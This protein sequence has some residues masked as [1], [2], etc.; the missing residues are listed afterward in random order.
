MCMK[1][2]FVI[3]VTLQHFHTEESD[4]PNNTA[5][6]KCK[7]YKTS[8]KPQVPLSLPPT[9]MSPYNAVPNH[10]S[11]TCEC[12][13]R[14]SNGRFSMNCDDIIDSLHAADQTSLPKVA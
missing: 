11:W 3:N 1:S 7:S 4:V 12:A 13:Y 14:T 9:A 6:S 2:V 8:V 10:S 5:I